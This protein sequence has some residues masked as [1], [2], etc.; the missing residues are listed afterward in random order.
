MGGGC[1]SGVEG[2]AS[3]RSGSVGEEE[4]WDA[5][6]VIGKENRVVGSKTWQ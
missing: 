3:N 4:G 5:C 2:V 1:A 6:G